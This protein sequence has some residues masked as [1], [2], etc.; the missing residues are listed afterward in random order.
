LNIFDVINVSSAVDAGQRSKF[1]L[2]LISIEN[3]LSLVEIL[4][5]LIC[6]PIMLEVGL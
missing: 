2:P 6:V 4:G 1:V 3:V 5:C